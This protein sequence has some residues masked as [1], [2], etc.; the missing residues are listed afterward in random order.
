[1]STARGGAPHGGAGNPGEPGSAEPGAFDP[2]LGHLTRALTAA[3]HP[4]ELRGRDA[5]LTAF[6]AAAQ[7]RGSAAPARNGIAG[8]ARNSAG[9]ARRPIPSGPP[10]WHRSVLLP[11]RLAAAAA[12]GFA[13]LA[14]L[15][16]A[17]YAQALPAPVQ[18]FAHTVLAPLGVPAS[19]PHHPGASPGS[20]RGTATGA[21]PSGSVSNTSGQPGPAGIASSSPA[22]AGYAVT[23]SVARAE[24]PVGGFAQFSG[25]VTHHGQAAAGKQ[26][27][28]FERAQGSS[29]WQLA[30]SGVTGRLGR[31]RFSVL[32]P[33]EKEAFRLVG[34]D[35]AHSTVIT[36]TVKPRITFW[37]VSGKAT[38]RLDVVAP[39]SKRGATVD[40]L[41]RVNGIWTTIASKPLGAGHRVVFALPA[42][43]AAG[44][45]YRAEVLSSGATSSPVWIPPVHTGAKVITTTPSPSVPPSPTTSPTPTATPSPPAASGPP[46]ASG[47][48]TAPSTPTPSGSP[49]T[50]TPTPTPTSSSTSS[51]TSDSSS[52]ARPAWTR[53]G[54]FLL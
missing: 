14:G 54:W 30:A 24:L 20:S 19:T 7:P 26:V 16:A 46:T 44:H 39:F 4:Y 21:T 9:Q 22:A 31:V 45:L 5:A 50:P 36:V 25:K 34:P 3:G 38:D 51:P 40:L 12:A 41:K 18:E 37:L 47:S 29:G 17:A 15:T 2:V 52:D 23:F 13:A 49:T 48:P 42:S 53:H 1:V 27:R 32:P 33:T 35:G 11:A 43:K 28:L 6:R 10:R 8:R